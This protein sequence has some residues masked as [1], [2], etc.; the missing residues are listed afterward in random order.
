MDLLAL[1]LD[2]LPLPKVGY[3]VF[4]DSDGTE[5]VLEGTEEDSRIGAFVFELLPVLLA[6]FTPV[7]A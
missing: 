4:G 3:D 5:S 6:D 7:G 1:E 2:L